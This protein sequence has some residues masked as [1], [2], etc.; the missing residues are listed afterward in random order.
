MLEDC[1]EM[2]RWSVQQGYCTVEEAEIEY[3]QCSCHL[4]TEE[5]R[6]CGS[7]DCNHETLRVARSR[8]VATLDYDGRKERAIR[9]VLA[10]HAGASIGIRRA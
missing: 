3:S 9:Y 1:A 5:H 10:R 2:L 4:N 8:Y 7:S 6:M